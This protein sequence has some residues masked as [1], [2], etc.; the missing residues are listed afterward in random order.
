MNDKVI[1]IAGV[2]SPPLK[3]W[4]AN[5][6]FNK[7]TTYIPVSIGEKSRELQK[8][9]DKIKHGAQTRNYF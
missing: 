4:Y 7:N 5:F 2:F 8:I 6:A 1:F 9:W 3:M